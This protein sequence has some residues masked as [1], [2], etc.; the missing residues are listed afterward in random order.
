MVFR[1]KRLPRQREVGHPA[2]AAP[3]RF[4]SWRTLP[5]PTIVPAQTAQQLDEFPQPRRALRQGLLFGHPPDRL[6]FVRGKHHL[7]RQLRNVAAQPHQVQNTPGDHLVQH[8][9]RL[10]P[11]RRLQLQLFH[12]TAAFVDPEID[13]GVTAPPLCCQSESLLHQLAVW[14]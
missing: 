14:V 9:A 6:P 3:Q 2:E 11:L 10:Q 13:L 12:P 1:A 5:G 7:A 4:R 8:Q